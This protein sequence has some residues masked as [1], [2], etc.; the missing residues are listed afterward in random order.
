M[1]VPS[2]R[3]N[4]IIRWANDSS[5]DNAVH[6]ILREA[7]A[8]FVNILKKGPPPLMGTTLISLAS[9]S[10]EIYS[11]LQSSYCPKEET[12]SIRQ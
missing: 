8:H 2:T 5:P 12:V 3:W 4:P 6:G 10:Q 7:G 11:P 9:D 1:I